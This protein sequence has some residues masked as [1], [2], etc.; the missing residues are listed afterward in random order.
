MSQEVKAKKPWYRKWWLWIIIVLVIIC[1][2]AGAGQSKPV[3]A[4]A[5]STESSKSTIA[6]SSDLDGIKFSVSKVRNDVTG[7]WRVSTIAEPIIMS[8]YAVD[9]YRQYFSSQ[10][11]IHAIVNFNKKTTTS[12]ST[13]GA[14]SP[15]T[16]VVTTYEYVDGEEHDA[17]K[18]FSGMK[19]SEKYYDIDTGEEVQ[20]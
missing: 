12:I 18:M 5:T 11:E 3:D 7:N 19:L 13:L 9:Y 14:I 6:T 8:D 2:I 20:L 16:I 10:D 4:P 15:D 17:K 1:L